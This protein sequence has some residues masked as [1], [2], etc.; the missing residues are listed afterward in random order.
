MEKE[1]FYLG[2]E[3][4]GRTVALLA[5]ADGEVVGEGSAGPSVY[6]I[7][8]QER[9]EQAIWTAIIAA[10]A[11]AGFNTRDLLKAEQALPD[12]TA[13]CIGMTGV[14]RP[15]DEGQI[16]RILNRFNLSQKVIVTSEAQIVLEAGFVPETETEEAQ[17]AF[18]VAVIAG[19]TGLAF[20][21]GPEGTSARAGGWGYLLGDEGSAHYIGLQA[22]KAVLRSADGRGNP[23]ALTSMVEREWK[24]A[25]NR[26]DTLSQRVYSLL[27]GLGTGGN[28]AQIEDSTE[29]FKRNLALLAPLVERAA[30]NGDEVA[31]EILDEAAGALAEAAEAAIVRAHLENLPAGKAPSFK[32]GG[33]DFQLNVKADTN[34]NRKIPLAISG[35][36]LLSNQGELRRRLNELLPQCDNPIAVLNPAEG[37]LRMA[38][39]EGQAS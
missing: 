6:S 32:V 22:V 5:T 19:D 11:S 8:G 24:L 37:A 9:T 36:V 7:M 2:I 13:I 35:S 3:S 17:A 1:E 12:I 16:R 30:A 28:K 27:A 38:L 31:G 25:E 15:K 14:E 29:N 23:T 4:T 39:R 18:G 34:S 21:R 20:A 26:P 10:F 33:I